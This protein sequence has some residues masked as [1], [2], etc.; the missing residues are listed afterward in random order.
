MQS[1][2]FFFSSRRRHTRY[3]RDWSSDV[4]SSD[5]G[6]LAAARDVLLAVAVAVVAI[7]VILTPW[8]LRLVRGLTEEREERVRTQERAEVAAHLHDSVL[9]KIGRAHV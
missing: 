8:W 3:W 6:A 7:G 1:Q 5:L 2:S 4:C 9:Q